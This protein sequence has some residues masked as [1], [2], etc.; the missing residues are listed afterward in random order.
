[1]LI[2]LGRVKCV[3]NLK[4]V[5]S[6]HTFSVTD[7]IKC[8]N[9]ARKNSVFSLKSSKF[10]LWFSL[11]IQVTTRWKD[12]LYVWCF[13]GFTKENNIAQNIY[14]REHLNIFKEV[15]LSSGKKISYEEEGLKESQ[16]TFDFFPIRSWISVRLP[17]MLNNLCFISRIFWQ[18]TKRLLE[19]RPWKSKL[20]QANFHGH[21]TGKGLA[22]YWS[23]CTWLSLDDPMY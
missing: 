6:F 2:D 18:L 20:I 19:L 7:E 22:D 1:M 3:V 5:A 8:A 4:I 9:V 10:R 11:A 13:F 15:L 23:F 14:T 21:C 16:L 17:R 12:N